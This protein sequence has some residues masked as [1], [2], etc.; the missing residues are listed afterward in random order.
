MTT[1]KKFR[2]ESDWIISLRWRVRN[3]KK[4][5]DLCAGIATSPQC[6]I[7]IHF[8]FTSIVT[9]MMLLNR[10]D[11]P[12]STRIANTSRSSSLD[13]AQAW[14]IHRRRRGG[15]EKSWLKEYKQIYMIMWKVFHDKVIPRSL[16]S[17][18]HNLLHF[19]QQKS[20]KWM[21]IYVNM[22]NFIAME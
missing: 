4:S 7:S 9:S 18:F 19:R 13:T 6:Y 3:S 17:H 11:A 5:I 1:I 16:P 21:K 15:D 14:S 22:S 10:L 20:I 2:R 12:F 8:H